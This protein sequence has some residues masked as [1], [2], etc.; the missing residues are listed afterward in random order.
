MNWEGFECY[1]EFDNKE[2][3]IKYC[4]ALNEEDGNRLESDE[5]YIVTYEH[6]IVY[7]A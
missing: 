5:C 4:E 3:A 6:E 2:D 7:T 1:E